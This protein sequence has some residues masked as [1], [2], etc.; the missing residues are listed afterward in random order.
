LGG[1]AEIGNL[2]EEQ[3][4]TDGAADASGN[5][6]ASERG[7]AAEGAEELYVDLRL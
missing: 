6:P 1:W 2:V 5:R 4:A 3:R 7:L